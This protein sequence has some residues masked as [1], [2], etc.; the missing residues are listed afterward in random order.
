M[1]KIFII[2]LLPIFL[3]SVVGCGNET[4][5]NKNKK[6]EKV[7]KEEQQEILEEYEDYTFIDV[8][9][10]NEK[11]NG[12]ILFSER[13]WT[14]YQNLKE[15]ILKEEVIVNNQLVTFEY[16]YVIEDGFLVGYNLGT[17]ERKVLSNFGNIK[18]LSTYCN[19]NAERGVAVL[20]ETG[21][22]YYLLSISNGSLVEESLKLIETDYT[23]DKFG[24]T[25]FYR[26][27]AFKLGA[28][29][30]NGE[31][32]TIDTSTGE[33]SIIDNEIYNYIC[34]TASTCFNIMNDGKIYY[35][36]NP[37][38]NGELLTNE[39][40]ENIYYNYIFDKHDTKYYIID[41][42]GYLYEFK[43]NSLSTD[44]LYATKYSSN[45]VVKIGIKD[46]QTMLILEN[47]EIIEKT[48]LL[49]E[50]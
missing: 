35:T 29:T 2:L 45:K 12:E 8:K 37:I 33:V 22:I 42:Q 15:I 40:N 49:I 50:L 46:N 21:K 44:K 25:K 1:K 4:T 43:Y 11:N 30:T 47:N 20:T 9:T 28:L 31:Q 14:D 3:I 39:N 27:C 36:N 23:F 7:E 18:E 48:G 16:K 24:H 38:L 13:E 26:E 34:G 41:R 32:V 5:E 10:Y 17:D 19:G 6:E